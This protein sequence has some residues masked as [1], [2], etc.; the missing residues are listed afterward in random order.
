VSPKGDEREAQEQIERIAY[1]LDQKTR[2]LEPGEV[3]VPIEEG[4]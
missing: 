2:D 4:F 3:R 1:Q